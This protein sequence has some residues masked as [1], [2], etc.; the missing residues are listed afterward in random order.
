VI[1]DL[2]TKIIQKVPRSLY[3]ICRQIVPASI[4][5]ILESRREMSSTQGGPR[6]GVESGTLRQFIMSLRKSKI[7]F[8]TTDFQRVQEASS[9][10]I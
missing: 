8:D 2:I 7:L 9:V 10:E 4:R 5:T 3:Q 1:L 6:L